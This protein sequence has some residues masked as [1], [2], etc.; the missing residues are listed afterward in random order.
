L[1]F[2]LQGLGAEG[3]EDL[4]LFL[5][6]KRFEGRWR[7]LKTFQSSLLLKTWEERRWT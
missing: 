7:D 3:N 2:E 1:E 4:F 6:K 5:V